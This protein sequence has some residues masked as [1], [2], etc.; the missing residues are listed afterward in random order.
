V[1]DHVS[2]GVADLERSRWFYN[3]A[4]RPLGLVRL[5]DFEGRGSDYGSVPHPHEFTITAESGAAV[6]PSRGAHLSFRAPD[7]AAVCAFHAAALAA[8]GVDDGA[9]GLRP[10]YHPSYYAAF[11]LDPDGHRIEAVCHAPDAD[12]LT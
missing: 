1:L 7:R 6:G 11:V 8:G 12:D 5:L 3:A 4:L 10:K 9:A 2:L